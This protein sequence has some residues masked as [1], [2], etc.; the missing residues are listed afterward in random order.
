MA[1]DTP[2]QTRIPPSAARQ[3]TSLGGP[4]SLTA[5]YE[6]T[7]NLPGR[8]YG[9][10]LTCLG[11]DGAARLRPGDISTEQAMTAVFRD[12]VDPLT[13]DALGHPYPRFDDGR[14]HAVVGYDLTFTAPKSV[15]V[16]WALADDATHTRVYAA[17]RAALASSLEFVEQRVIRTRDDDTGCR[18]VRTRGMVAAAFDHW[19]TRAGDPNLHTHVVVANKVQGP[20]GVWRSLDGR[21]VHAAVVTVSELYDTLLADE[22]AR[23]LPVEW[24]MRERGPRRAAAQDGPPPRGSA[25]GLVQPRPCTD[26]DRATRP[27]RPRADRHLRPGAARARR[28]LGGPGGDGRPGARR[29]LDQALGVDHLKP[30]RRRRAR[31]HAAAHGVIGRTPISAQH[32]HR[33][34]R[35]AMRPPG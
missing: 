24:S 27:C 5:S 19:D 22:L 18:Q 29:R 1:R 33:R 26:R 21:T 32:R 6:Q 13:D 12:G 25:C 16:L 11:R 4:A 30:R 10:G 28:R 31:V 7:G 8:W 34:G 17:H 2:R 15:S 23:R 14:R 35:H 9:S 20:D 3:R